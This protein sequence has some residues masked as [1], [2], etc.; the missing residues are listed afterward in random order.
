MAQKQNVKIAVVGATGNVGRSMLNILAERHFPIQN[1]TALASDRSQGQKI[2]YGE[3]GVLDVHG[4]SKFDF[5]KTQIGL[6]SP[7]GIVSAEYAPKAA[8]QGCIVIDNT[9]HF[10]MHADIPL[11]IPEVNGHTISQYAERRIIANPNCSTIQLVMALKPLHEIAKVKRVVVSTYQS[12]S[13][14]GKEA[15]DELLQQTK[16]VFVNQSVEPHYFAKPIAFNVIPQIDTFMDDGFTKEE[17]KMTVETKKILDPAIDV[18]ATCVRV[19]VFIG[20]AVAAHIEFEKP[21]TPAQA[22]QV[23]SKTAGV[24]VVD[25]PEHMEFAT[26]IEW[27]GEDDVIVSRLRTDP[28]VPHGLAMWIV[29]DNIRK[30]AALNAIQ[31]AEELIRQYL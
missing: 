14:A 17:W 2:S 22:R 1:I 5:S 20:H 18:V 9:S 30:G 26:P 3:D 6:F 19:P 8:S 13:G 7:G 15:M 12:T 28:T 25:A 10:R 27:A 4:L 16:G 23:L 29:A 31:I 21:I 11:V 24:R